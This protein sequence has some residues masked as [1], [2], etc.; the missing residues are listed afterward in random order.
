MA[1]RPILLLGDARLYQPSTPVEREQ[2]DGLRGVVED[3]HD[4]MLA[5][6]AEHGW[7]RAIAAPQIGVH[8]RIVCLR[9]DQPLTLINPELD[10][11]GE[12]LL[13]HWEDCMSFPELLVRLR[14][15]AACRLRY[16]DLDWV[17]REVWLTEDYAELLQHEVDHLDGV[18]SVQR[19]IDGRSIVLRRAM[20]DKSTVLRGEFRLLP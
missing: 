1:V 14:N 17:E 19:A 18:L 4:T 5:F 10:R 6:Q 16:R 9:V 8:R 12:E 15:P 11:H 2:L 7:G 20:P 3:L 13:E